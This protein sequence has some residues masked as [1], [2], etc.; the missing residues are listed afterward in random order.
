MQ[1]RAFSA[2]QQVLTFSFGVGGLLNVL[3]ASALSQTEA[4]LLTN[5]EMFDQA[6]RQSRVLRS[7]PKQTSGPSLTAAQQSISSSESANAA[8]SVRDT[9]VPLFSPVACQQGACILST[10]PDEIAPEASK[11][12]ELAQPTSRQRES[13]EGQAKS[14]ETILEADKADGTGVE[15]LPSDTALEVL[16]ETT[17]NAVSSNAASEAPTQSSV[18]P[19]IGIVLEETASEETASEALVTQARP[20]DIPNFFSD[21]VDGSTLEGTSDVLDDELGTLRLQ[22]T[23]SRSNEELGILRLLQTAQA[24]PPP[25][26]PPTAFLG[27]RLGFF[28]TDNVFRS[29]AGI[30]EQIYQSGL[31]LYLFPQLSERTNFYAITTAN[32]A[33]YE[34]DYNELEVQA[35]L[36]HRLFPSTFV[37]VGWRNQRL[38]TPGYR[39]KLLGVNYL[40]ALISHRRLLSKRAWVDGFYQLRLGFADPATASRFRQTL[41]TS[42]NYAATPRLRTSLLYQLDLDDYLKLDRYDVSQQILGVVSYNITPASRISLFGGTRFGNSSALG[43]DLD[44]LFY[45]AGLNVNVPLF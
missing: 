2:C 13:A 39:E 44:D 45:G 22:Q 21:V 27:G 5:T 32:L 26:K 1:N 8:S 18:E 23:R 41:I 35:G 38:Y 31:S 37:Q 25:P 19:S 15:I 3:C 20:A 42:I 33:R 16:T 4:D 28:N 10:E 36:R 14:E 7:H 11:A 30:E 40:D 43:V 9:A 12:E 29:E 17:S 24:T 34:I 6:I